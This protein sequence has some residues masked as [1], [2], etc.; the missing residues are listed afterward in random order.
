MTDASTDPTDLTE[1]TEPTVPTVPT[2]L[3]VCVRNAG[4]SQMA[5]ALM[6]LRAGD[7]VEVRS[8]GTDPGTDV[9]REAAAVV[10]QVGATFRGEYPKALLETDLAADRVV[11]V[12][13]EALADPRLG[14]AA[15]AD[16]SIE[17][18]RIDEPS[19]RGIEGLERL[20]LIRDDLDARVQ[21]L[22][23]DL[24]GQAA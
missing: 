18:W 20:A 16:P 24:R 11:V 8:A 10:E 12:G 7:L 14:A 4:K 1:P 5:A 17:V 9:N 19:E 22:L 23:A 2:V 6:R 15:D 3:F 21:A 13:A